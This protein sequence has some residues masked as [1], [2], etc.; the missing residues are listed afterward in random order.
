MTDLAE[1]FELSPDG[2]KSIASF[3]LLERAIG[4]ALA[5]PS[6]RPTSGRFTST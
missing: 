6:S 5:I 2:R 1:T 4:E 3:R